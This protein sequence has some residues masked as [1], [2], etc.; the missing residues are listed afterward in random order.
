LKDKGSEVSNRRIK[1]NWNRKL[2]DKGSE[3]VN[4][5]I[6]RNWN[7]KLKEVSEVVSPRLK[8]QKMRDI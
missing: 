2:K 1:R 8:Y 6:K 4:R 3:V 5:R 7:R